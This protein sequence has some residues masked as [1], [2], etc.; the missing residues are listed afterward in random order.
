MGKAQISYSPSIPWSQTFEPINMSPGFLT[1]EQDI[2]GW[3]TLW[4]I[5]DR[6]GEALG[7]KQG[8]QTAWVQIQYIPGSSSNVASSEKPPLW[9]HMEQSLPHLQKSY[10]I[11]LLVFFMAFIVI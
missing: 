5:S 6:D 11:A 4:S 2:S 10:H 1:S 9:P 8:C 3:S 7:H